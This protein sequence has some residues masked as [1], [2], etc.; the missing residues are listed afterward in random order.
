MGKTV[1]FGGIRCPEPQAQPCGCW[2][3]SATNLYNT[4]IVDN[5]VITSYNSCIDCEQL[6]YLLH[7]CK[8]IKEDII[9]SNDLTSYIG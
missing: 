9:V 7:D 2:S 8:G 3:V 4:Q 1:N 5:P 6:C